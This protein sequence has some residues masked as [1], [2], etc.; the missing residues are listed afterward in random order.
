MKASCAPTDGTVALPVSSALAA[1]YAVFDRWYTAF[2]GPSWPNHM[3]S[4]SATANGGTNTGDGYLCNKGDKYPQRTIF[5]SLQDSGKDWR[6]YYNDSAWNFFLD[7]FHTK[8]GAN[9]EQPGDIL[10]YCTEWKMGLPGGAATP[11][12]TIASFSGAGL[13]YQLG[14]FDV[15]KQAKKWDDLVDALTSNTPERT[16]EVTLVFERPL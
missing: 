6:Y 13:S 9:G 11:G 16:D 2:P 3:F 7:F 12:A 10:R 5:E 8:A 14:L 1:E 15:C 4:Y